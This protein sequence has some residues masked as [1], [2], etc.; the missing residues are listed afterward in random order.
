M[1]ETLPILCSQLNLVHL[2]FCARRLGNL[3]YKLINTLPLS[4]NIISLKCNELEEKLKNCWSTIEFYF[5]V[6]GQLFILFCFQFWLYHTLYP[7][8]FIFNY[9]DGSLFLFCSV[10]RNGSSFCYQLFKDFFYCW[11]FISLQWLF[12]S[13]FHL[14]LWLFYCNNGSFLLIMALSLFLFLISWIRW[15]F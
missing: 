6:K 5:C 8:V 12:I 2:R 9:F 3:E 7:L 14:Y 1:K 10:T 13:E 11:L 15:L 4:W